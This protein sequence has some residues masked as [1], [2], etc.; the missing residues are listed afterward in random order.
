MGKNE[1]RVYATVAEAVD[2]MVEHY[3][4]D[5]EKHKFYFKVQ[6]DPFDVSFDIRVN[7]E[8]GYIMVLS[9]LNFDVPQKAYGKFVSEMT[10]VNYDELTIGSYDFSAEDGVCMF[11]YSQFFKEMLISQDAIR[12]MI[13]YVYDTVCNFNERLF[14]AT[15]EDDDDENGDA[16]TDDQG[17]KSEE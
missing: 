6:G 2:S 14:N 11:R 16:E 17:V 12:I 10:S 3:D 13:R 15:R 4:K 5:D 8:G 1:E 7:Y 9:R